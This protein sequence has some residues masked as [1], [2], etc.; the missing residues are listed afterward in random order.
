MN[1]LKNLASQTAIYGLS[2]IVGRFLN[3]LL[4]P[5]YTNIFNPYQYGIITELYAYSS[6]LI[7]IF[8]Y[9]METAF[10]RFIQNDD[11]KNFVFG[12]SL[13]SILFSS[14]F[15]IVA[16][17][18]FIPSLSIVL[19]Y[20]D[21]VYLLWLLLLIIAIDALSAIPFAQL[22]QQN[23][24]WRFALLK[25]INISINIALNLILLLWIPYYIKQGHEVGSWYNPQMGVGY[26]FVSNLIASF[27]TLILLI[28]TFT[29]KSRFNF[30][31]WKQMIKYSLPL[32]VAGLAGMV[33]ETFDRAMLKYLIPDKNDAMRQ[34]GIYGANYKISILMTLFIQT[35]RFAAEPF[36][37]NQSKDKNVKELYAIVMKYF[38]LF[39]LFIFLLVMLYLH[40]I[41]YFIG[42]EFR[43]GLKVVPILLI[44]NLFLGVFFNLSIWY[45]LTNKTNYGAYLAVFGAIIT[46]VLNFVLIP[47]M[48]YIGAAWTTLICYFAMTVLSYILGN[49]FY[50]IPY[51]LKDISIYFFIAFSIYFVS[52]LY[53]VDSKLFLT[54]IN[55]CLIGLFLGLVFFKEKNHLKRALNF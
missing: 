24:A 28:P 54:L 20:Q 4:V 45:K 49:R 42:K 44:A 13:F 36:F 1:K 5:L 21:K 47:I 6:F 33:N 43:E 39:G 41:Q 46:I 17:G 15:F 11:D 51:P 22:R 12:T 29:F 37:F 3:Y 2:S 30:N 52:T 48:G 23:K 34:L 53:S 50:N 10:F 14:L 8:T 31:L 27:V 55:T 40:Y 35:F 38:V 7:I 25:L 19:G 26:V 18:L 16:I 32:L 9:G